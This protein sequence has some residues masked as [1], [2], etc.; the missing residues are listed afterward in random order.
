MA[1]TTGFVQQMKINPGFNLAWSW[2]GPTPTST[3]LLFVEFTSSTT[4]NEAAQLSSMIETLVSCM[5]SRREVIAY[6]DDSD[7]KITIVQV[8]AV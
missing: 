3:E 7:A 6:H 8:P 4:P 5:V 2:I 1:T